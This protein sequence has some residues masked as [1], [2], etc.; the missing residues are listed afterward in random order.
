MEENKNREEELQSRRE[1]F[2]KAAKAALPILGAVVLSGAAPQILSAA[3]TPS[4]CNAGCSNTCS[5][6]CEG[7]CLSACVQECYTSCRN[8]CFRCCTSLNKY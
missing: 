3:T 2:K 4:G 5:S 1:F 6:H 7:T 8:G